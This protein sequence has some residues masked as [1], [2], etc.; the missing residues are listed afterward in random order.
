MTTL[1]SLK[2]DD[3]PAL[4]AGADLF[5]SGASRDDLDGMRYW[6]SALLTE[7][8]PIRLVTP[9][10]LAPD[11]LCASVCFVGSITALAELPM[12]GDEPHRVLQALENRL[13]A[14]LDAV[15]AL[16][17]AS[18]NAL[19]PVAAAALHGLPLVDCDGMGRVFPLIYQTSYELAGLPLA[20]LAAVGPTGDTFVLDTTS[21]ERAERVLRATLNHSGGWMLTAMYPTTAAQL[22]TAAIPG[23]ISRAVTV[24]RA[25]IDATDTD[26]LTSR[27]QASTGSRVLGIGRVVELEQR[28]RRATSGYPAY[29]SSIVVRTHSDPVRS[30]RLEAQ[31]EL[32]LALVDGAVTAAVPDIICLLD[33]NDGRVTGVESVTVGSEVLVLAIPP[34]P[35][36]RTPQGLAMVGPRSFGF[37]LRHPNEELRP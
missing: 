31:N 9:D 18:L 27:L 28:T 32:L 13:G 14:K 26:D 34:A 23:S 7:R 25:L 5:A 4:L 21:S 24:G 35:V 22:A 3:L 11:A 2:A 6:L 20:P 29:P 37:E 10:E 19:M 8:D 17:V 16:D 12:T 1:T 15:V 36:W 33:P 30:I